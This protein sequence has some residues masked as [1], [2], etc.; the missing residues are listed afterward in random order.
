MT[1]KALKTDGASGAVR[2]QLCRQKVSL[3]HLLEIPHGLLL[4]VAVPFKLPRHQLRH[5]WGGLNA[6]PRTQQQGPGPASKHV[7]D[8]TRHLCAHGP[9]DLGADVRQFRMKLFGQGRLLPR[10]FL[11]GGRV[12]AV[13]AQTWLRYGL[14]APA[15]DLQ[16]L[17]FAGA[18][19][20]AGHGL[21]LIDRIF[22]HHAISRPFAAGDRQQPGAGDQDGVVAGKGCRAF[23][24]ADFH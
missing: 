3:A 16:V 11:D 19:L 8:R 4:P 10:N 14:P 12:G 24:V 13:N 20:Q 2:P 15:M 23:G 9:N 1:L 18:L 22:G 6:G 7:L 17:G 5:P 21:C